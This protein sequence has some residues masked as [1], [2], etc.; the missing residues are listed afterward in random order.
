MKRGG[1]TLLEMV[2][3]LAVLGIIM[4]IGIPNVVQAYRQQKMANGVQ[5][6]AASITEARA[7]V[8]SQNVCYR[9]TFGAPDRYTV[10][11][12]ST[13]DC[14]GTAASTNTVPYGDGVALQSV[15][16]G[17][18]TI[19]DT[20]LLKATSVTPSTSAPTTASVTF[21]SPFG[22]NLEG[23][24]LDLTFTHLAQSSMTRKVRI[25]GVLGT[26]IMP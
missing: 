19:K 13:G 26:V 18:P 17:T 24:P 14:S 16:K 9:L 15:I 23:V 2:T 12:F 10:E 20:T 6:V 8:R 11:R 1:F 22:T 25:S 5:D 21:V 4:A 7:R 3:V